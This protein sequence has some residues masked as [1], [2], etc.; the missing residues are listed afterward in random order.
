[1]S[2]YNQQSGYNPNQQYNINPPAY[3]PPPPQ[4][5]QSSPQWPHMKLVDWIITNLLMLIPIVNIILIFMWAFGRDVNPSKK[6][7]FQAM[8][9]WA[10]IGIV[11]TII[12]GGVIGAFL[13]TIVNNIW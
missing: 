1:M 11:F 13:A 6:T 8:L 3:Q 12:L 2:D 9:I 4:Q 7:Y 5:Y 10:L